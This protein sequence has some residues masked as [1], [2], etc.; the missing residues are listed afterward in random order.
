MQHN[1]DVI[2][3]DS[4]EYKKEQSPK[5]KI[6]FYF[7][8][9]GI[10]LASLLIA[11]YSEF[12]KKDEP[13]LEYD[14]VSSTTFINKNETAANLRIFLDSLDIQKNDL[15]ITAFNI[16]VSNKG[17]APIRYNDYDQ[18]FFGLR[19]MHGRLLEPPTLI[20]ESFNHI[21]ELFPHNDSISSANTV[22]VPALSLDV[23]DYYVMHVVLLHRA[24][25]IPVF[26][27]D[28]R[29]IGQK[30]IALKTLKS[31]LLSFWNQV[32][33]GDWLVHFIRLFIYLAFV[34]AAALLV[35]FVYSCIEKLYYTMKRKRFISS[36]RKNNQIV[37][38]VKDDY[39]RY[40]AYYIKQLFDVFKDSEMELTSQYKKYKEIVDNNSSLK[41]KRIENYFYIC[42]SYNLLVSMIDKGY[43]KLNDGDVIGVNKE[44][45]RSVQILYSGLKTEG[46]LSY[47]G[48]NDYY[49]YESAIIK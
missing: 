45:R 15:N 36:L 6:I 31:P 12:I 46:L 8:G 2:M 22:T 14:I 41:K 43:L 23:D 19:I 47:L 18:G 11:I 5:Y 34:V 27:P 39:I 30:E 25:S 32:F 28:G 10:G 4:F 38:S 1:K 24:D 49:G 7:A 16:K 17:S 3:K 13:R 42:S 21:K 9:W 44:V 26:Q 40:G 35:G 37:Q 48:Y 33:M 20:E 29:V